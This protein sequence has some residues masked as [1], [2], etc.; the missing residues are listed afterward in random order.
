MPSK[1]K[2]KW[3]SWEF[4]ILLDDIQSIIWSKFN[5]YSNIDFF[6]HKINK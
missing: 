6:L 5:H 3:K 4:Y 1:E 2:T